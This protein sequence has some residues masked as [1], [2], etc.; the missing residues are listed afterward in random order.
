MQELQVV[1]IGGLTCLVLGDVYGFI[2]EVNFI[3][4]LDSSEIKIM[5][6]IVK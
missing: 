5:R 3:L 6:K 2:F 4:R 1:K